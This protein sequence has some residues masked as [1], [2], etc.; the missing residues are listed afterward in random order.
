MSMPTGP[1]SRRAARELISRRV[2]NFRGSNGNLIGQIEGIKRDRMAAQS[3]LERLDEGTRQRIQKTFAS[4]QP[5]GIGAVYVPNR[6]AALEATLTMIPNGSRVA[7]GSST[8]L[9]QIGFVARMKG[10]SPLYRYLNA[11]WV[12]ESDPMKR[13]QLRA[14]LSIE[15][16]YFLGSVQAI[17]ETGEIVGADQSGSRQA[18]YVYGPPHVI[19]VAG[20]N[21]L[22]ATLGDAIRRVREVA[23]PLED[24]RMKSLGASGS[25]IG[26]LVVYERERPGRISLILVGEALGF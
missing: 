26:K 12:A 23:L 16:D 22:V 6:E 15:A 21:K 9:E 14:K 18:F 1:G 13:A 4:L 8:T 20:I 25:S 17:A 3:S 11:E 5:R 7:H 10:S 2:C 24:K 19:W